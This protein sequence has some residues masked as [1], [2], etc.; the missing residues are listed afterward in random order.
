MISKLVID[1]VYL[2]NVQSA[3][4]SFAL[5]CDALECNLLA[6][7]R[8][9]IPRTKLS[10]PLLSPHPGHPIIWVLEYLTLHVETAGG[11]VGRLVEGSQSLI[12]L[13]PKCRTADAT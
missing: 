6:L 3:V 11:A 13:L 10:S 5:H 2:R 9:P 7:E 4:E 8:S 12:R 1:Q